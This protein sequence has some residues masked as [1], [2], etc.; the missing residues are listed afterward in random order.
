MDKLRILVCDDS[1]TV[2]NET[3]RLLQLL[4]IRNIVEAKDGE[5]AILLCH[6]TKPHLVFMDII[7]PKKD[8]IA[9]LKEIH[10]HYPDIRVVMASSTSGLA[11][12]KKSKRLGAYTFIQKPLGEL[13]VKNIIQKYLDEQTNTH[14]KV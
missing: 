5:E 1:E 6:E 9:A 12:L 11:H 3:I 4:G 13:E 7:M 2:R 8:G 10:Q 14:T